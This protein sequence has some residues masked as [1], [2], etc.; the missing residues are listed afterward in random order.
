[1]VLASAM[2]LSA[3]MAQHQQLASST[4]Q[5]ERLRVE[6]RSLGD[7]AR[8]LSDAAAVA[9]LARRDYGL[10]A[11]GQKAYDILPPPGAQEP[12]AADS[13]HVPLEEPPVVPGSSRSQELLGIGGDASAPSGVAAPDRGAAHVPAGTQT[14][15][16]GGV[17]A[18][19]DADTG[20]FWSRV[21]HTLEFW[22]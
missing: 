1:V 20:G 22:S 12:T 4:S 8:Q 10:V 3:L 2:P 19:G 9:G 21:T 5:I 13:G 7:E 11:A 6:N 16:G 18:T 17:G 14:S 15:A